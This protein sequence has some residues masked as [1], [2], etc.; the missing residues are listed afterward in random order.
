MNMRNFT[1]LAMIGGLLA[2]MAMLPSVASAQAG[3]T[4]SG[5]LTVQATVQSSI[6]MVFDSDGTGVALSSGAGTA[7]ATLSFGNVSAYGTLSSNV[8]RSVNGTT[9]Y[10][11][12]TPFDVK[13]T[14][15]NSSS[16]SYGL[17]AELASADS[18]NT[19][20]IGSN[21]LS[22]TAAATIGSTVSYGSDAP[23]TLHLTIPF[24]TTSGT[25]ISQAI[26]F[27]ATSN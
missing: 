25:A 4:S 8:A 21:T 7:T 13:V 12:S 9:D 24:S 6:S 27:T 3:N 10:T 17:T 18:T 5:T 15:A 26:N 19:W 20:A 1:K 14:E 22:N 23:Y 11:I 16:A 2:G